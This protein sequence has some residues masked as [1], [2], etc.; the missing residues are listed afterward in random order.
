MIKAKDEDLERLQ[1]DVENI[2][3]RLRVQQW[4][5][6]KETKAIA[7]QIHSNNSSVNMN[8]DTDDTNTNPKKEHDLNRSIRC[9]H[10]EGDD[11]NDKEN[12]AGIVDSSA[13][14]TNYCNTLTNTLSSMVT[15]EKHY[16]LALDGMVQLNNCNSNLKPQ[17]KRLHKQQQ[18]NQQ[19]PKDQIQK[20]YEGNKS[21]EFKF[22]SDNKYNLEC[23]EISRKIIPALCHAFTSAVFAEDEKI[24]ERLLGVALAS[25]T[26][27]VYEHH[28]IDNSKTHRHSMVYRNVKANVGTQLV[29]RLINTI[30]SKSHSHA[31]EQQPVHSVSTN[32][33]E[34]EEIEEQQSLKTSHLSNS[35]SGDVADKNTSFATIKRRRNKRGSHNVVNQKRDGSNRTEEL[36]FS[37]NIRVRTL[38]C[39]IV[40][41][42]HILT[43]MEPHKLVE[44]LQV[45]ATN[46]Y[47]MEMLVQDG[48][49]LSLLNILDCISIPAWRVCVKHAVFILLSLL[50]DGP[51][52]SKF[53]KRILAIPKLPKVCC[54]IIELMT[55]S[56]KTDKDASY[57]D[58]THQTVVEAATFFVMVLERA[59]RCPNGVQKVVKAFSGLDLPGKLSES[60]NKTRMVKS[61]LSS[62]D[63]NINDDLKFFVL[64][65]NV[66]LNCFK[67]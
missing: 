11:D 7:S 27:L 36:M 17:R 1:K 63:I 15:L 37:R 43:P 42:A 30:L 62:D 3:S 51:H 10:T 55:Q 39:M 16:I 22:N 47:C 56:I 60:V 59:V 23:H 21:D 8:A 6:E 12:K 31:Y 19:Q 25:I 28:P 61:N 34:S 24:Q 66:I 46:E 4:K 29:H 49:I 5:H 45:L 64:N 18:Q 2:K 50:E 67:S 48:G 53:Q 44:P 65:A 40:L 58:T 14:T 41:Q 33:N 13:G 26:R 57:Y 52:V 9:G 32:S 20:D 38:T 35:V 54:Q